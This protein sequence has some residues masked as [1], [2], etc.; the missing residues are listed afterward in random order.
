MWQFRS[1]TPVTHPLS[2]ERT[3][4]SGR[5]WSS[6]HRHCL[7][8]ASLRGSPQARSWVQRLIWEVTPGSSGEGVKEGDGNSEGCTEHISGLR[9]PEP[10]PDTPPVRTTAMGMSPPHP[11]PHPQCWAAPE[12]V[13]GCRGGRGKLGTNA[14]SRAS[15]REVLPHHLPPL[16][17]QGGPNRWGRWDRLRKVQASAKGKWRP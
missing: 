10:E 9:V 8:L 12:Q 3:C 13:N 11:H 17:S 14:G 5:F 16:L 2:S 6:R 4:H 1:A 7:S 15:V